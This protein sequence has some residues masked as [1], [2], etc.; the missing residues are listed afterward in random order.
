MIRWECARVGVGREWF[1]GC[2]CCSGAARRARRESRFA[3][4]R[5]GAG[6]RATTG[7]TAV[8]NFRCRD[9][10]TAPHTRMHAQARTRTRTHTARTADSREEHAHW[11]RVL[12]QRSQHVDHARGQLRVAHDGLVKRC[13]LG[14]RSRVWEGCVGG[15]SE[16][17]ERV[18]PASGGEEGG[19]GERGLLPCVFR[20]SPGPTTR[21]T[22]ARTHTHTHRR[23]QVLTAGTGCYA[24]GKLKGQP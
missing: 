7:R 20:H 16:R 17:G 18:R 9:T 12:G 14:L 5:A 8:S 3:I 21:P 15:V 24:L 2:V 13:E 11:M 10:P 23:R 4:Q 6:S 1:Q 22:Q 19:H